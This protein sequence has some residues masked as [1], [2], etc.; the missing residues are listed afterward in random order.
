MCVKLA[1]RAI[2]EHHP[3]DANTLSKIWDLEVL[4]PCVDGGAD[5]CDGQCLSQT[6]QALGI[7]MTVGEGVGLS[8]THPSAL[9]EDW[10]L[11][12]GKLLISPSHAAPEYLAC[13][14]TSSLTA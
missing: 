12:Y 14:F 3:D 6:T 2:D 13:I 1:P 5:V 4:C 7:S 8:T 9:K 10:S 11:R